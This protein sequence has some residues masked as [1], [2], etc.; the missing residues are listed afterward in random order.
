MSSKG[1]NSYTKQAEEMLAGFDIEK[2]PLE[3]LHQTA[4]TKKALEK[5]KKI[6]SRW[7]MKKGYEGDL[8]II[9]SVFQVEACSDIRICKRRR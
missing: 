8:F 3:T 7:V 1:D 5:N 2:L 6:L 4:N 9:G